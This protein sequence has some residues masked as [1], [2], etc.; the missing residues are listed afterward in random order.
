MV[1]PQLLLGALLSGG[2]ALGKSIFGAV[3]ASNAKKRA[4][5]MVADRPKYNIPEEYQKAL[6]IYQNL[7][8][9]EMP[10]QRQ[11]E[12][13]IGESTARTMAGAER[14]AIS[15]NVYQGSVETAQDKELQALQNLALMGVQY[16]T[17]V[18]QNLAGVQTQ[19]GQL[20]D[21]QWQT[22][23]M[24]PWEI[25]KNIE[26]EQRQAGMQNLFGGLG[27]MGSSVMNFVGTKYM[28]EI[29]KGLQ[30]VNSNKIWNNPNQQFSQ[31]VAP[32]LGNITNTASNML[33][34]TPINYQTQ[35]DSYMELLK[36]Q[37]YNPL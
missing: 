28:G 19:M 17:Q 29:M 22:N 6:G 30:G 12:N 13:L 3:Q 34:N 5:Q 36:K 35:Y 24:Q 11:Y 16:K 18:Q 37:G 20:K 15:S 8:Q 7:A 21:I 9:G 14:G 25:Q 4:K 23:V 33:R 26:T 31:P 2:L 27:E 1:F 10:G 32:M